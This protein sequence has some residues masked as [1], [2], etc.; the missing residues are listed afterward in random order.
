MNRLPIFGSALAVLVFTSAAFAQGAAP[1]APAQG[2]LVI[3]RIHNGIV[4]APDY[5][6]TELNGDVAQLAGAYVGRVIDDKLLIGGAGYW[7]ASG[8]RGSDLKYGGVMVGWTTAPARIRFGARGL[9]GG[10]SG[11][12]AL[13]LDNRIDGRIP[14]PRMLAAGIRDVRDFGARF[15][16]RV[17]P[18]LPSRPLPAFRVHEDFFVFEPQVSAVT[19]VTDHLAVDVAAGYRLVG[20]ADVLGDRLGGATGSLG[21]Q[22]GW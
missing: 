9:V 17:P 14:D 15:G 16:V 18:L 19:K 2:P 21:L 3:E 8:P 1:P 20:L 6:V 11:T 10:G 12:L 7:L 4:V 13:S 22:F 5:K